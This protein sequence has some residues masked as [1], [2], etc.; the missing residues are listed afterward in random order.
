MAKLITVYWRDI[1]AQVIAKHR[2]KSAKQ[3]LSKR[4]QKAI[5]SAAM[6]AGKGSS[7]DY[8]EGWYRVHSECDGDLELAVQVAAKKLEEAYDRD[9]LLRLVRNKG[10]DA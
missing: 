5:D 10:N 6:R 2:R 9:Q 7:N 8:L 3:L 1:P 4:F